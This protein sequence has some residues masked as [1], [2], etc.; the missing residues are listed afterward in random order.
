MKM[1]KKTSI[2]VFVGVALALMV[3]KFY[4]LLTQAVSDGFAWL[5]S[6]TGW[7]FLTDFYVQGFVVILGLALILVVIFNVGWKKI[8]EAIQ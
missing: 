8:Q 6:Q 4:E 2:A 7:A 3:L 1:S 5:A